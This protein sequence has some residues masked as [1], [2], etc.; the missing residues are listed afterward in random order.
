M[1]TISD[2]GAGMTK[3]RGPEIPLAVTAALGALLGC[4]GTIDEG[5][6]D[7]T[8]GAAAQPSKPGASTTATPGKPGSMAGAPGSAT[9]AAGAP[10]ACAVAGP[11]IWKLTPA[12]YAATAAALVPGLGDVSAD[13]RSTV[14]KGAGFWNDAAQLQMSLPHVTALYATARRLAQAAVSKPGAN[15]D[16]CLQTSLTDR[17]CLRTALGRFGG[18]AFRRPLAPAEV[19]AYMAQ[20]EALVAGST[21]AMALQETLQGMLMSPHFLFRTELGAEGATGAQVALTPHER[22]QKISYFLTDAPPDPDLRA[23][24]DNNQLDT[25]AKLEAHARRLL[26]RP[27]TATGVLGYFREQY[28][29]DKVLSATKDAKLFPD[30]TADLR[31]DLA[32]ESELFIQEVLWKADARLT[33]LFTGK[34]SVMNDRVA[35]YYKVAGVTGAQFR[36]VDLPAER[37]GFVTSAGLLASLAG[38]AETDVV[39]RGRYVREHMLCGTLPPPPPNVNAVPPPP[40]GVRTQRERLDNHSKDPSCAT[41]H[42]LMDPLGLP[43]ETFDAGGRFRTIEVGKPIVTTGTLT[44]V[45]TGDVPIT[46]A[47]NY[48]QVLAATPEAS[49]C[50][51]GKLAA[52]ADSPR[53]PTDTLCVPSEAMDAFTQSKGNV[54]EAIVKLASSA[55]FVTRTN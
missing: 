15:I 47:S 27:E 28:A 46:D 9:P 45:R 2:E 32:R 33:T 12:Q 14:G 30:F 38:D 40:D 18:R 29:H 37:S 11:R 31:T 43:F 25:P 3:V 22:A 49:E 36:R 51:L 52:Y 1:P 5:A 10:A 17:A 39:Q 4:S 20:F 48:A 7:A 34:F 19:D 54:V 24:A 6:D 8:P 23:A 53:A 21:E 41:C 16:P 55:G 13:L 50:L 35:K 26:A 42:H 44:G